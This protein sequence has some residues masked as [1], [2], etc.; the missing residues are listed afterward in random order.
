MKR[1][2]ESSDGGNHLFYSF[3]FQVASTKGTADDDDSIMLN[4]EE[5][6]KLLLGEVS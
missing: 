1:L 2:L 6:E 3:I 5:D 4:I